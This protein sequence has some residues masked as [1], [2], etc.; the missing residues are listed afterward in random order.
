MASTNTSASSPATMEKISKIN[1]TMADKTGQ[2]SD[3]SKSVLNEFQVKAQRPIQMQAQHP[4]VESHV[5]EVSTVV[6]AD[7]R[8]TLPTFAPD[9]LVKVV[10]TVARSIP[11]VGRQASDQDSRPTAL[12]S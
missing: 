10:N 4:I 11:L 8:S 5:P 1:S 9:A 7:L 12:A 2:P 3:T 6:A